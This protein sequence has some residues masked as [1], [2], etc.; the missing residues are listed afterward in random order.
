VT[1]VSGAA[2][3]VCRKCGDHKAAN[4]FGRDKHTKDG[5]KTICKACEAN[6]RSSGP[7]SFSDIP[8]DPKLDSHDELKPLLFKHIPGFVGYGADTSGN[9][10]GC[11]VPGAGVGRFRAW[12]K[13]KPM[14]NKSNGRLMAG[15]HSPDKNKSHPYQ[16]HRL[17]ML[18][19]VG[20]CPDGLIVC[21]GNGDHTDNRL[22]NLRY[23]TYAGN[24]ADKIAHGRHVR[25]ERHRNAKLT[26]IEVLRIREMLRSSKPSPKAIAR[27]FGVDSSLIHRIR[28][29]KA[30][31]WL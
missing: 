18:T 25:G 3:R 13:L 9:I 2:L 8:A 11:R 7:S 21:H 30:W 1:E 29:G 17:I 10:W 24:E 20:P 22:S 27:Q 16:I 4:L 31:G 15:L 23:D 19:F 14:I 28:N 12:K 5:L 26:A 6:Y